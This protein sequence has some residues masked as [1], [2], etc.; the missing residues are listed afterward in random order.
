ME[1]TPPKDSPFWSYI[2]EAR[3]FMKEQGI[4]FIRAQAQ[5]IV[6]AAK[7]RG[8]AVQFRFNPEIDTADMVCDAK[9]VC[10]HGCGHATLEKDVI[11]NYGESAI[12]FVETIDGTQ[13][14]FTIPYRSILDYTV[15][16]VETGTGLAFPAG[17][18]I[19]HPMQ[20]VATPEENQ[21]AEGM[22]LH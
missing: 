20:M 7:K 15:L 4:P 22:T 18:P 2:E 1:N 14:G 6:E 8:Y 16:E 12:G 11:A 17:I 10:S 21:P 9:F 3:G 19:Y 13:H 5:F